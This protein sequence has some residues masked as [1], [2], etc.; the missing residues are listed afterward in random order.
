MPATMPDHS[1]KERSSRGP[2][3]GRFVLGAL[4]A[5]L[6]VLAPSPGWAQSRRGQ[7]VVLGLRAPDG[8]DEVATNATTALRTAAR[9][10]GFE[11]P[12]EAPTV[13]Q[14]IAA[15][16]CDDSLPVDCLA[17]IAG[18]LHTP[19]LIYGSVRRV[20]RGRDAEVRIEVS[21][22]DAAA[23]TTS[24]PS[25]V[26]VPRAIGQDTDALGAPSR[27]LV[28][29]LL[30]PPPPPP[31][32]PVITPPV[33]T[34]AVTTT[35]AQPLPIRRYIGY[36]AV[37]VGAGLLVGGV[38]AG[39]SWLNYASD[40]NPNNPMPSERN[41]AFNAYQPETQTDNTDGHVV[42]DAALRQGSNA[43]STVRDICSQGRSLLTTEWVLL[44]VG[45][46][47][48]AVGVVLIVTDNTPSAA[49]SSATAAEQRAALHRPQLD[50]APVLSA[51]YQGATLQ[52]R[53]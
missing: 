6:V 51:G 49:P 47:V 50:V 2:G 25:Q 30:P 5:L 19:R 52:L 1:L 39:V 12:N 11:V 7:L 35:P 13:E 22:Y 36:G 18:D 14:S 41:R 8:D 38:I 43:P 15:F 24:G 9:A 16:G 40:L 42:C 23:R 34:T 29:E 33:T 4:A 10:A 53:F 45:A 21:A 31:P 48:A 28:D 37:G 3:L 32:P 44:G 46:A 27:R 20:G 17:Q 26:Q